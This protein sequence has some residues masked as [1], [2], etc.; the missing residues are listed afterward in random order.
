MLALDRRTEVVDLDSGTEEGT[1]LLNKLA[2]SESVSPEEVVEREQVRE[3]VE[4]ML[5]A[6][7]HREQDILRLR[8]GIGRDKALTLEE[9]GATV[10]LSRERVRQ[11]VGHAVEKLRRMS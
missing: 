1:A 4:S 8:Y 6:L 2:D 9:I 7:S 11:I 3:Q 10:H 5:S